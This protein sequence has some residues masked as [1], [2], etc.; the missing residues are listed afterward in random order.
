MAE[1]KGDSAGLGTSGGKSTVLEDMDTYDRLLVFFLKCL[2]VDAKL[3][4]L[5]DVVLMHVCT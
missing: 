5:S 3:R 1:Q 4:A 2:M